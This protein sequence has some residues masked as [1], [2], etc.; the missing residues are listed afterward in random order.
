MFLGKLF[1]F[2]AASI[3]S[4]AY[5]RFCYVQRVPKSEQKK[6][7]NEIHDKHRNNCCIISEKKLRGKNE[8]KKSLRTMVKRT[9]QQRVIEGECNIS[10]M[11]EDRE[12]DVEMEN[13]VEP[14][15]S[16]KRSLCFS[17]Y[18]KWLHF[19]FFWVGKGCKS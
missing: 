3:E 19:R 11:K 1:S 6:R 12:M 17:Y 16:L 14:F 13:I 9:K 10:S 4:Y 7:V 2:F 5:H 15:F 8:G 18:N